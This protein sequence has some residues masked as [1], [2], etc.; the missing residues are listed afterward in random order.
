MT[1]A[2][3]VFYFEGSNIVLRTKQNENLCV[4][5]EGKGERRGPKCVIIAVPVIGG[6][7]DKKLFLLRS[8]TLHIFNLKT[9][10][11][12]EIS[13]IYTTKGTTSY[14]FPLESYPSVQISLGIF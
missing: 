11:F 10:F 3:K 12:F 6:Q 8:F 2:F 4:L 13:N 14:P 5:I 7:E 1:K 9:Y